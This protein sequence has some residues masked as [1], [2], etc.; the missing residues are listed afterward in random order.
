[1]KLDKFYTKEDVALECINKVSNIED[2]DLIIEPSA[3][4][5]SFS[6]QISCLAYDIEP[7]HEDIIKQDFLTYT[8]NGNYSNIL[9]IG[10]PPFG[11]RSTLAKSFIKHSI[12]IG[13]NTIAFILPETFSKYRNQLIFPE[14]WQ[15]IIEH[16][17]K[18]CS[19]VIDKQD[20][21]VPTKFYVWTK[22]N[23]DINLRKKPIKPTEDFIFF[24]RGSDEADFCING[25]NGKV[26]ELF[27]VTNPKSE[28]YIKAGVKK[29]DELIRIFN[30][31]DYP[32]YSSVNG[33]NYWIG[34]QEILEGYQKVL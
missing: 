14:E 4:N 33:G 2:Y 18:R 31:I 15:L 7:E 17:L 1:M 3:G 8:I 9:I 25:N 12:K 11:S 30:Q 16:D 26:K 34:Q 13:A 19:F 22:H 32:R 23:S 27:D 5:G 24:T 10:N 20:Y 21:P 29:K 28:H 6:N